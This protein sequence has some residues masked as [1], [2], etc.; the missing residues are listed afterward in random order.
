MDSAQWDS[1]SQQ[2]RFPNSV[3]ATVTNKVISEIRIAQE[4]FY[5]KE[6]ESA[7]EHINKSI[8]MHGTAEG[9]AVRGS[10]LFMLDRTDEAR[11]SWKKALQLNPDMPGLNDMIQMLDK[12]GEQ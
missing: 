12:G 9:Y 2:M 1:L 7:L 6:Y 11:E 3:P 5:K 8:A 4:R 10:V